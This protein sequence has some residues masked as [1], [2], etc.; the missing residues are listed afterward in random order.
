MAWSVLS[1]FGVALALAAPDAGT[2]TATTAAGR[3]SPEDVELARYLFLLE[4]W[5]LVRDLELVELL[6]LI[7]EESP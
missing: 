1:S 7:E 2:R 5:E 4:N 6:P 3:P